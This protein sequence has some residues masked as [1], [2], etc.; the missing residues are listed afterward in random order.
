[1]SVVVGLSCLMTAC[2]GAHMSAKAV[3]IFVTPR[4]AV[5]HAHSADN[6]IAYKV[7]VGYSDGRDVPQTGGV[8]WLAVGSWVSF[9]SVSATA[10]CEYPAPQG[11][12]NIPQPATITATA[13]VDS[14][15]FSDTAILDCF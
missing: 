12:F 1:M 14:Q 11:A 4:S 2:G 7:V 8:Q 3:G 15:T 10:T 6:Q 5:A 13:T 9:D